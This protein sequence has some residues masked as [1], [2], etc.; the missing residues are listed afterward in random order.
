MVDTTAKSN[1]QLTQCMAKCQNEGRSTQHTA[2]LQKCFNLQAQTV[3][4]LSFHGHLPDHTYILYIYV[5]SYFLFNV[6]LP[7]FLFSFLFIHK[8]AAPL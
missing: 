6:S 5:F 3:F 8:R 7:F 4:L 2:Q 1:Y